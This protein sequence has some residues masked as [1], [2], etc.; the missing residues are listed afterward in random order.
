M[1][2]AAEP[3]SIW[4]GEAQ[5]ADQLRDFERHLRSAARLLEARG[6]NCEACQQ[7]LPEPSLK[8]YAMQIIALTARKYSYALKN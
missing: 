3:L 8:H 2:K 6:P 4:I 5:C 1:V 7:T